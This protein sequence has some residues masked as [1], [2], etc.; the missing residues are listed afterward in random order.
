[1]YRITETN[2]TQVTIEVQM[3]RCRCIFNIQRSAKC[4]KPIVHIQ[5]L[6]VELVFICMYKGLA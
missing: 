3:R 1:M 2:I 4:S 5:E 6:R